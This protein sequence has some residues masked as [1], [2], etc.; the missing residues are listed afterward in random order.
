MALTLPDGI[1]ITVRPIERNEL[2]RVVLR[3]RPDDRT[4]GRLFDEQG[5]IGMAAWEGDRC[6]AQLHCYRVMLP[7]GTNENWRDNGANWWSG[8]RGHT[9]WRVWGPGMQGIRVAGSAWCHAC[10]HVGRT[11]EIFHRET[12]NLILGLAGENDAVPERILSALVE[13]DVHRISLDMIKNVLRE[14]GYPDNVERLSGD[15]DPRY[16]GRGIG[17]ALCDASVRWAAE[18]GYAAV[19]GRGAPD[20]FFEFATWS[21]CLPWTTYA[22]LGFEAVDTGET[23]ELPNWAQGDSPPEVMAQ[24]E[25]ALRAE[26][27]KH[28]I[29]ERLMLLNLK[30]QVNNER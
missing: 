13:L 24:V 23:D 19:M 1:P 5:T 22:R 30:K 10:C 11:L 16:F 20:G 14:S 6:V 29:R 25:A 27:P 28:E 9:Q 26:R 15:P 17:T 12:R 4:I 3:C 18:H 21:G 8:E 2:D 7:D